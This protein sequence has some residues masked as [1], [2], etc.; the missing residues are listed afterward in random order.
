MEVDGILAPLSY[1]PYNNSWGKTRALSSLVEVDYKDRFNKGARI[2]TSDV[3]EIVVEDECVY[4]LTRFSVYKL[5]KVD[6]DQ[7]KQFAK[8]ADI[9]FIER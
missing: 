8:E 3:N 9:P 1:V 4:I 7:L 6:I 5:V 2:T